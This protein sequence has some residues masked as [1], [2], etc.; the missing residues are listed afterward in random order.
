MCDK[1]IIPEDLLNE[2]NR[3]VYL[4]NISSD[5]DVTIAIS[6]KRSRSKPSFMM[7]GTGNKETKN[8]GQSMDYTEELLNMTKP[9]AAMF[10]LLMKNRDTPDFTKPR[11]RS[12]FTYIDNKNLD[13]K[14]KRQIVKAYKLLRDKDLI[15]RVKRGQYLINPR[16]VISGENWRKEEEVYKKLVK[17][18]K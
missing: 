2:T 4:G 5:E 1:S 9:E 13:E 7:V 3:N 12:N 14:E 18:I 17:E 6:K 8:D 15:V 10:S 16:L 11:S